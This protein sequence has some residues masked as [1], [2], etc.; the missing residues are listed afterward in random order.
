MQ[1]VSIFDGGYKLEETAHNF[2]G[3]KR[4]YLIVWQEL[5]NDAEREPK[6]G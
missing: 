6:I 3:T 4:I 5:N 2:K 1:K